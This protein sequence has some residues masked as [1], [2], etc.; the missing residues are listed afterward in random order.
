M[1]AK[2]G[3]NVWV[4]RYGTRFSVT[5]EGTGV[6]L[7][8]PIAQRVAIII[9]RWVARANRSELIVQGR[10]GRIRFRDSHGADSPRAEG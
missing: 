1:S 4:V 10:S 2:I 7:V 6:Y 8:P 5:E 9:A 3:P